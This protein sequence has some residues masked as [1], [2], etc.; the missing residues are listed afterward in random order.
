MRYIGLVVIVD[1]ALSTFGK[2]NAVLSLAKLVPKEPRARE[3]R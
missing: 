2:R 1:A 3:V